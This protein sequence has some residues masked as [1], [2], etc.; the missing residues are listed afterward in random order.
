M[1]LLPVPA[2]RQAVLRLAALALA[3]LAVLAG[4]TGCTSPERAD[5]Q[6]PPPLAGAAASSSPAAEL[7]AGLTA[8]L[9]ER[10]YV[11]AT[12]SDGLPATVNALDANSTGLADVLGAAY[13]EAR[14]PLLQALRRDDRLLVRH[15]KALAEGDSAAAAALRQELVIAQRDLARVVRRVVPTLDADEVAQRLAADVQA[16]LSPASYER[17]HETAQGAAG[18]ARLLASGVAADR[19]LDSPGTDAAR[20]RAEVTGLLT[21]HVALMGALARELRSPGAGSRSARAA[22]LLNADALAAVLGD[23]YPDARTAFLRSWNAHL[24]RMERYA[25]ERAAGRPGE[26]GLVRGYPAELGR[27]LAQHVDDLPEQSSRTEL[28]RALVA[29]L[30]A[31]EASAAASPDAAILLQRA[32]ADVLPAAA[33][34]SA[35][36]AED[37]RLR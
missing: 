7:Q 14:G 3:V 34:V 11:V 19:G 5:P 16:Q 15:A 26:A 22:L 1:R 13:D 12:A 33:L 18:T 23:V 21:E 25:G 37:L 36:M 2:A 17:L 24:L 8:L 31:V 20:L 6:A 9:V 28:E 35:A 30:A 4:L 32:S 10:T 29:L 27:L